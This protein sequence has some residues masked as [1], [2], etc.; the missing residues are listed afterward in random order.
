MREIRAE[1][2]S[3]KLWLGKEQAIPTAIPDEPLIKRFGIRE[4]STTGSFRVL[5]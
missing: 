1:K 5:S 2:T 4:G 3:C